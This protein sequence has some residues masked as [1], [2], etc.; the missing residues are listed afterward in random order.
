M[1]TWLHHGWA[2][3]V[4]ENN[5]KQGKKAARHL[6]ARKQSESCGEEVGVVV[7]WM[8]AFKSKVPITCFL[9]LDPIP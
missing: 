4:R 3:H 6:A 1:A 9:Q 2:I 8:V 5:S 7:G